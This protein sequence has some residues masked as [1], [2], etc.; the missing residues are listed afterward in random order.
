RNEEL[1][2]D[3]VAPVGHREHE[4]SDAEPEEPATGQRRSLDDE[5]EADR[6]REPLAHAMAALQP[7]VQ[8]RQDEQRHDQHD[9]EVVRVAR[10][11]VRAEDARAVDRAVDVDLAR[12][13]GDRREERRVQVAA[14]PRDEELCDPVERVHRDPPAEPAERPPEVALPAAR[15]PHDRGREERE[16]DRPLRQALPPLSQRVG[17]R[18]VEVSDQVHEQERREEAQHD[19]RRPRH[20]EARRRERERPEEAER[21]HVG[22]GD[23]AGE[24][25][26]DLLERDAEHRREEEEARRLP[27]VSSS[28]RRAS[29]WTRARLDTFRRHSS[30]R[31]G[32]SS[33][34]ARQ[35]PC[36]SAS[37]AVS[38]S[39]SSGATTTPAPASRIRAAAAP[40]GGTAARI[41]RS[42]ARYSKTLPESTPLPRPPASGIRS[43]SASESRC[44][45]SERRRGAYGI[46]S[47]RSP[48]ASVSAHSRS[49]ERKSP[50]KRATTSSRPDCATAV[51]NGRGSRLPKN[52][53]A[54]VILNRLDRWCSSPAKSS[55]SEP[56]AIVAT[57]PFGSRA[58]ISSE[59]ASETQTI[60]SARR[61]GWATT[62][63]RRSA[64]HGMPTARFTAAPTRCTDD[65][66]EV[67]RTT[68]IPS[69]RAIWIAAGTAV[70]FHVTFSS[71][72]RNRRPKSCARRESRTSPWV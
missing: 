31:G 56:F 69:R 71:G 62:E 5:Q 51:R 38:P 43:S 61:C 24:V 20:E 60:A 57:R 3:E 13:A 47:S 37:A 59:I 26:V 67:V 22:E 72:T 32:A 17:V 2:R 25:P 4:R 8:R 36:R 33:E 64:T 44:S 68:S 14:A 70:R 27:H 41:G 49:D 21:K 34:P 65:G 42:A 23:R 39:T 6:R 55:K 30:D 63:S 46:S 18:E 7:Q 45:S 19:R 50:R 66:G 48:R 16:V 11:R 9:P 40:S 53:P 12:T 1:R 28:R 58:R 52:E 15:E 29:S 35:R 10:H 54:C